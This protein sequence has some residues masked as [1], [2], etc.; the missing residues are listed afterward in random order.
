MSM[1]S[2]FELISFLLLITFAEDTGKNPLRFHE[3]RKVPCRYLH[4][5]YFPKR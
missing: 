5:R 1:N 3:F 4:S 2:K